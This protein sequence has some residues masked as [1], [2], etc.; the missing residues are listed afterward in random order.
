MELE[1]ERFAM[2]GSVEE[3]VKGEKF[4]RSIEEAAFDFAYNG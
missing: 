3:L 1:P 2:K 4:A